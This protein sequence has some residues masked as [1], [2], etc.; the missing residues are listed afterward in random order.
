MPFILKLVV[1]ICIISAPR[2]VPMT[3]A[4]PP[5]RAVPPTTVAAMASSSMFCPT[6]EASDAP[7]F[8]V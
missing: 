6:C 7:S 5:V 8:A 3:V 4:R 1:M 2:T